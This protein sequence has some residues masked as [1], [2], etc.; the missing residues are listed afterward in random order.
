MTDLPGSKP[1]KKPKD[2]GK[3]VKA[4]K[5]AGAQPKEPVAG[6]SG[7][8]SEGHTLARKAPSCSW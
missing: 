1:M 8:A 7:P 6:M 4:I 2:S 5:A 3:A